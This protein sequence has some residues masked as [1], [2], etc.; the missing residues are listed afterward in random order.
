MGLWLLGSL[1]RVVYHANYESVGILNYISAQGTTLYLAYIIFF[2]TIDKNGAK[3]TQTKNQFVISIEIYHRSH[4][5]CE[6]VYPDSRYA[7]TCQYVL[8]MY[9]HITLS[10]GVHKAFFGGFS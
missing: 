1:M 6:Y 2:C 10:L 5:V 3:K 7:N 4:P 9:T 8:N